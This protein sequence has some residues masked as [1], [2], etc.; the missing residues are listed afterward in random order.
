MKPTW[1]NVLLLNRTVIILMAMIIA[2]SVLSVA[3]FFYSK[4]TGETNADLKNQFI[5]MNSLIEDLIELKTIVESKE[6]KIGLVK[7]AGIVSA[8][9]QISTGMGLKAKAI[10]PLDKTVSGEFTEESAEFHLEGIDI[11]SIVN[12]LYKIESSPIPL[13]LKN[14][15]MK[16]TFE[17]P[18][19]FT[20]KLTVSLISKG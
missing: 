3:S 16:T 10:K 8:L 17:D 15:S 14:A 18:E 7:S 4:R 12:L 1:K 20:L 19:R 2:V 11:N 5:H 13:K 6:K 9:E